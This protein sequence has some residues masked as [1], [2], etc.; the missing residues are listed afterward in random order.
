MKKLTKKTDWPSDKQL[1]EN[2]RNL[3]A[4]LKRKISIYERRYEIESDKIEDAFKSG[5]IKD[6]AEICDWAISYDVLKR[7]TNGKQ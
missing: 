3:K 4:K 6:T 5:K 2:S 1:K 7:I